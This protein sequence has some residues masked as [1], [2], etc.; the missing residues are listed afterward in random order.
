MSSNIDNIKLIGA[1]S[2]PHQ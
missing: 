1:Q 2:K